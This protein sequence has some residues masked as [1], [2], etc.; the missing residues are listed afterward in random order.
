MRCFWRGSK[1]CSTEGSKA[2]F[3]RWGSGSAKEKNNKNSPWGR[4]TLSHAQL[5]A[6]L[7]ND[8]LF[9]EEINPNKLRRLFFEPDKPSVIIQFNKA[10]DSSLTLS[11]ASY[12]LMSSTVHLFLF[13]SFWKQNHNSVRP[14][15]H[16]PVL[17]ASLMRC[18]QRFSSA[19]WSFFHSASPCV[20]AR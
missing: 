18:N 13:F 2:H 3:L 9:S 19:V 10:N 12:W 16:Q 7:S 15:L 17:V 11:H 6:I 5:Q 4:M 20:G 8:S 14:R 1:I